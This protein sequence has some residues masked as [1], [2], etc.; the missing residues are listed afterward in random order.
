MTKRREFIKTSAYFAAGAM[1]LPMG[2][3]TNPK[4]ASEEVVAVDEIVKSALPQPGVQV[5]SVRDALKEDFAGSLQKLADIGYKYVEGYGL[6][7][8][9]LLYG[10]DPAEYKKVVDGTGM[11][12]VSCHSIISHQNKPIR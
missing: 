1:I 6:G 10:M 3:S 12:M 4:E 5:Y 9:G 2:C 8:D 7:A 11:K